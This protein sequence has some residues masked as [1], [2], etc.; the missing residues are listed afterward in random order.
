MEIHNTSEECCDKAKNDVMEETRSP[1]EPFTDTSY[2]TSMYKHESVSHLLSH[3]SE[4]PRLPY[5]HTKSPKASH[6]RINQPERMH[7]RAS[8]KSYDQKLTNKQSEL[9][10]SPKTHKMGRS[11]PLH[12]FGEQFRKSPK[13]Q[14]T[15]QEE[16]N[17]T[18]ITHPLPAFSK[19]FSGTERGRL[20]ATPEQN[21]LS[22]SDTNSD[23]QISNNPEDYEFLNLNLFNDDNKINFDD[24]AEL[25]ATFPDDI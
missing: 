18:L 25:N 21:T 8:P 7:Y 17:A 2:N 4:E 13:V 24:I 6:D 3:R 10:R 20:L 14:S 12:R 19:A 11:S 5:M 15:H 16:V 22:L 23:D 1:L 9:K